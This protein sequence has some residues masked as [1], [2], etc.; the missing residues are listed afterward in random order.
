MA[1]KRQSTGNTFLSNNLPSYKQVKK[2]RK[3]A[4]QP[5]QKV[6]PKQ[7]QR[8]VRGGGSQYSVKN[9]KYVKQNQQRNN[10]QPQKTQEVQQTSYLKNSLDRQGQPRA[11]IPETSR[12]GVVNHGKDKQSTRLSQNYLKNTTQ[13]KS[14]GNRFLDDKSKIGDDPNNR[15][16]RLTKGA[17][18]QKVGGWLS[19]V[20]DDSNIYNETK[21]DLDDQLRNGKINKKTYDANMKAAMQSDTRMRRL[22]NWESSNQHKA[23]QELARKGEKIQ[24][25]GDKDITKG[26]KGLNHLQKVAAGTYTS[27]AQMAMD[28]A[29]GPGALVSMGVSV[30]GNTLHSTKQLVDKGVISKKEAEKKR[31]SPGI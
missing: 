27:S 15:I 13:Q 29:F 1:K 23:Y 5:K 6:Q 10:P 4:S 9:D 20:G 16:D 22:K 14:L 24:T 30:Y 18:K 7:F 21:K 26:V 8:V 17:A 12:S 2:Q 25:S 3:Q 28:L 31:I 11:T 19:G